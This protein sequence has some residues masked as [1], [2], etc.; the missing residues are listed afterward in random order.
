MTTNALKFL[1]APGIS[2]SVGGRS[3]GTSINLNLAHPERPVWQS[4]GDQRAPLALDTPVVDTLP[5][6]NDRFLPRQFETKVNVA[7]ELTEVELPTQHPSGH[8]D[9]E[10]YLG[11]IRVVKLLYAKTNKDGVLLY[12]ME[13]N[14]V[15]ARKFLSREDARRRIFV[16]LEMRHLGETYRP[17]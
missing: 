3:S 5:A 9:I 4:S 6:I 8:G 17:V 14:G 2:I 1:D 10:V 11:F 7:L 12:R 16:A 13:M 15:R